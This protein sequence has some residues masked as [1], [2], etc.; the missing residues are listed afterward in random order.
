M[1]ARPLRLG[2]VFCVPILLALIGCAHRGGQGPGADPFFTNP[3]PQ[4]VLTPAPV[5]ASDR[6]P[7]R[8]ATPPPDVVATSPLMKDST[9]VDTTRAPTSGDYVYVEVLPEAIMKVPPRYPEAARTAGT[10]GTVMVQALVK[11]DGSVG[12]ARVVKSIPGLDEA[13]MECVRQW[14][15]KPAMGGDGK[16]V[17]VWSAVPVKFSLH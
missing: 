4:G 6:P 3:P 7:P 10:Q 13:A 17:A 2:T 8:R 15:F 9:V 11:T 12:D 5:S 14:K 16:P 1:R